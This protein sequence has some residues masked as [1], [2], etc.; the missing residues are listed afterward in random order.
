MDLTR[1]QPRLKCW[2]Y[3]NPGGYFVTICAYRQRP[4]FGWLD[5]GRTKLKPLGE[6]AAR[7]WRRLPDHFANLLL[8]AFVVMPQHLHGLI[9]LTDSTV[10]EACLA[11]L[12]KRIRRLA[13]CRELVFPGRGKSR[14]AIKV[15]QASLTPTV[16]MPCG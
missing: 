15:G 12:S 14:P 16:F 2:D 4:L 9:V 10:G 11:H 8:D 3:R 1:R 7:H 13:R 5:A 6:L